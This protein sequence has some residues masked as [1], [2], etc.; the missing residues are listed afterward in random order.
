MAVVQRE[1]RR[2][3]AFLFLGHSSL[4]LFG[5]G[6][7]TA[8]SLSGALA[9]WIS[10]SLSLGGLGLTLRALEA[11]F[12]RL[13]LTEFRGLYAQSPTLAICLLLTGLASAGFPGTP[14][15]VAGEL[16][17]DSAVVMSPFVGLAVVAVA[18]INGIAIVRVYSPACSPGPVTFLT[19]RLGSRSVNGS[20]F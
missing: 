3:F 14:G 7:H 1:A 6:L 12:G 16:V 19:S 4:V 8:I 9:L 11:R 17:V 2:F 15:F 13:S 18:A 5:L 10:V 20:P